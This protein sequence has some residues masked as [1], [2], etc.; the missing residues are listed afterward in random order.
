MN[1]G[2][3]ALSVSELNRQIK[4]ILEG[5]FPQLWVE[6]E[7]S[8][9]I[10]HGSGHM[11]FTLKD[12]QSEIRAVL[13]RGANQLLHF[14][15]ENGMKVLVNC[16][17]S[18]YEI[19]GQYQIVINRMEPAGLGTLFLAF[20]ALKKQLAAEGLFDA[21]VKKPLPIIPQTIGVIT[22]KSGAAVRDILQI[23]ARRAPYVEVILRPTLV[24]GAEAA[25]DIVQ[26]VAELG[27]HKNIDLIILG[28]GGGSLEDLWPFNEEQVARAIFHCPIPIIS[29]VGHET[30]YTIADMVADLRASTPSAAAELAAPS[31]SDLLERLNT[32]SNSMT[33][34]ISN[35]LEMIWQH[36]DHLQD[37]FTLTRPDQ[38]I[39]QLADQRLF[40]A[41]QLSQSMSLIRQKVSSR[42]D[43]ILTALKT[44]NPDQ[45]L[46]RGFAIAT[47]S[48]GKVLRDP[49]V[50]DTGEIFNL[51]LAKGSMRAIKEKSAGS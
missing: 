19:R 51:R 32:T 31:F 22:S 8:N 44:M 23:L 46:K 28:R 42:F 9:F 16:R 3:A 24:Q 5:S 4:E 38:I 26:A 50:L 34:M 11:Y 43:N 39:A 49:A 40:M 35:K 12:E 15:P 6:G 27:A 18:V 13:F 7:I 48:A 30:D 14:K 36:M 21:D 17:V 1:N 41:K 2:H 20:E 37:R 10:R 47:T 33:A 25:D 45:V 29:G